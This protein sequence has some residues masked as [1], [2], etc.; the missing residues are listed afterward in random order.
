MDFVQADDDDILTLLEA[1]DAQ[2]AK[3][4]QRAVILQPG[5][6]GDCLLTLPLVKFLKDVL[7]LGGVDIVGHAEYVGILPERTCVDGVRSLDTAELHRLF[8]APAGFDLADRDP[9]IHMFADYSW[10]ITFLGRA[11]QR[12][13]A[14]PDLHRQL[15]PQRRGDYSA[16]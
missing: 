13:R 11:G 14:E 2:V 6:L 12:L 7:D 8:T 10:I 16:S 9:L 1:T 5:A 4:S 15:Q 3:E